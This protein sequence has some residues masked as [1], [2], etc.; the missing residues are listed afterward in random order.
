[1]C[2]L[3]H[4]SHATRGQALIAALSRLVYTHGRSQELLPYAL[5]PKTLPQAPFTASVAIL[6]RQPCYCSWPD[7]FEHGQPSRGLRRQTC[8]WRYKTSD[9][10][11]LLLHGAAHFK[12]GLLNVT[13]SYS[14]A[15][16]ACHFG[17][18]ACT[19]L[20][21]CPAESTTGRPSWV[22][23]DHAD[24][25]A[26]YMHKFIFRKFC[27]ERLVLFSGVIKIIAVTM[28]RLPSRHVQNGKRTAA[29]LQRRCAAYIVRPKQLWG[30]SYGAANH[31]FVPSGREMPQ[32]QYVHWVENGRRS[33]F[34]SSS[35][36]GTDR[37][38][39]HDTR[40]PFMLRTLAKPSLPS[41]EA[42]LPLLAPAVLC[43]GTRPQTSGYVTDILSGVMLIKLI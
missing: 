18:K 29:S 17:P 40:L 43:A 4:A 31:S 33:N 35:M 7:H 16:S 20:V 28:H 11:T 19:F 6:R 37:A 15:Y 32:M 22:C 39:T 12:D 8:S 30:Y 42:Y 9:H 34:Q 13:E 26:S 23:A 27:F 1:M 41:C 5:L 24:E 38:R 10:M 25:S 2:C 3:V 14:G 21:G 36:T